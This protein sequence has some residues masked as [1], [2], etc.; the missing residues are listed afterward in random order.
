MS[1]TVT[2]PKAD[3]RFANRAGAR[4]CA[5]CGTRLGDEPMESVPNPKPTPPPVLPSV[6]A[7]RW[8][9]RPGEI[10]ARITAATLGNDSRGQI[11]IDE[12]LAALA[13]RNGHMQ[14]QLPAGPYTVESVLGNLFNRGQDTVVYLVD[15]SEQFLAFSLDGVWSKDPLRLKMECELV[16][17]VANAELFCRNVVREQPTYTLHMLREVLAPEV[18]DA[19]QAY[20]GDHT[21]AELDANAATRRVD[22]A[23]DVQQRLGSVLQ[24]MGLAF[25]RVRFVDIRHPRLDQLRGQQEELVLGV[26]ELETRKRLFD[27]YTEQQ[28]HEL[29]KEEGE[30]ALFV[31]RAQLW[32]RMR[33]A[34]QQDR[35]NE[36][37]T[38]EEWETFVADSDRRRLLREDE[39]AHFREELRWK[40]DDRSGERAQVVALAALY[41]EFEVKAAQL[42]EQHKHDQNRLQNELSLLKQD[43][44]GRLEIERQRLL[45][46][47]ETNTLVAARRRDE[48]QKEQLAA[49]EA[50]TRDAAFK[51]QMELQKVTDWA[52]RRKLEIEI[53]TLEDKAD[54]ATA[55]AAQEMMRINRAEKLRIEREHWIAVRRAQLDDDERRHRLVMEE[56]RA[57]REHE[58]QR[59]AKMATL[60]TETL[61]AL[62]DDQGRATLLADLKRTELLKGF[63]QEQILAMAAEKNPI[64]VEALKAQ[65]QAASEGQL[66]R[67]EAEKWK[68]L[69]E[70]TQQQQGAVT[71]MMKE[72]MDRQEKATRE[73]AER[74]ERLTGEA[75]RGMGDVAKSFAAKPEAG[76]TLIIGAGGAQQLPSSGAGA[77]AAAPGSGEQQVV[78]CPRCQLRSPAGVKF[79]HNCG[80]KFF[81]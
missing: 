11:I 70:S 17:Q 61:I 53:E 12:G 58:L 33:R 79:C 54:L 64:V 26:P 66:G 25:V 80:H 16:V 23:V 62:T 32:D 30:A 39:L 76:S 63:S 42:A 19:A 21:V 6:S 69:A 8:Q 46:T 5:V 48:E 65:F 28:L 67:A 51:R 47:A 75:L 37:T 77:G 68:A 38:Q 20:L 1:T 72:F 15:L 34:V 45:M 14:G 31:Q 27:L 73:A 36:A 4:F 71:G 81:D 35:L 18:R 3:C 29:A 24:Q 13:L 74:Q 7:K 49:I 50:L 9:R 22:F 78:I 40:A 2:C 41:S 55:A 60:S 43:T 44:L 57:E 59:I 52:E 56:K 10:A